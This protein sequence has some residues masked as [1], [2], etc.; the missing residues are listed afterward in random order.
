MVKTRGEVVS[1]ASFDDVISKATEPEHY[2]IPKSLFC[3][4]YGPL[5]L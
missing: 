4:F 2:L 5:V 3:Q 1:V